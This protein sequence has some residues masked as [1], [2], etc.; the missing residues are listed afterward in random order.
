MVRSGSMGHF[1]P[2]QPLSATIDPMPRAK[3]GS[4]KQKC[5]GCG[6]S[7]DTAHA[8]PLVYVACPKCGKKV[9]AERTFDHFALI[10]TL[11]IGGMYSQDAELQLVSLFFWRQFEC[12]SPLTIGLFF[13][14][15]RLCQERGGSMTVLIIPPTCKRKRVSPRWLNTQMSCKFFPPGPIMASFTLSWNWSITAAWMI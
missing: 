3:R 8:D 11:G 15:P 1:F 9:R 4:T 14:L 13:L 2:P 6:A 5:P 7:V 10:E 12:C